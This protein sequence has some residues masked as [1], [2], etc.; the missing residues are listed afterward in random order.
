MTAYKGQQQG[1]GGLWAEARLQQAVERPEAEEPDVA[2]AEAEADVDHRRRHEAAP[3]DDPRRRAR[4]EH[5]ADELAEPCAE[6]PQQSLSAHGLGMLRALWTAPES[7]RVVR[8]ATQEGI[9]A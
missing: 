8:E 6:S 4:P 5:P 9:M 3:Q 2:G 7:S 1:R